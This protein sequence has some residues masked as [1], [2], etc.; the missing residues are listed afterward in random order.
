[1]NDLITQEEISRIYPAFF[2]GFVRAR[3]VIDS[4]KSFEDIELFLLKGQG[5]SEGSYKVYMTAVRQLY[6]FTGGLNPF[7]ITLNHIEAFYDYYS[8]KLDRNTLYNKIKGLKRFFKGIKKLAPGWISPFDVMDE[9]LTRKLNRSKKGK[10]K[11]ALSVDEVN[12]LLSYL[13]SKAGK[14]VIDTENYTLV[15]MLVTS[16]LRASELCSLRWKDIEYFEGRWTA[17]F[18]GK[19]DKEAEQELYGPAVEVYKVYFRK[20][21]GRG[22]KPEDH[23]FWTVPVLKDERPAPM[24]PHALWYR[25]KKIGREVMVDRCNKR[26]INFSPHLFRRTY[27]TALYRSGMKLKAI[28]EKTRHSNIDVLAKH[29]ISDEEPASPYFEKMLAASSE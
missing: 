26:D 8:K 9:R 1:M 29:Y 10:T 13:K 11:K 20:H 23:L 7:Q 2:E 22:P 5:L 19:G 17:C 27:A 24:N 6:E 28:M 25:I 12:R 3:N 18:V 4:I 21:F 15:F 14:S 16:G